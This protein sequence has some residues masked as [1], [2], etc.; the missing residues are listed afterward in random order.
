[1]LLPFFYPP[2]FASGNCLPD[3]LFDN[4]NGQVEVADGVEISFLASWRQIWQENCRSIHSEV[5]TNCTVL[6]ECFSG[7]KQPEPGSAR[8]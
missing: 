8:Q 2:F 1:M 5:R 4:W 6:N 3:P 7:E